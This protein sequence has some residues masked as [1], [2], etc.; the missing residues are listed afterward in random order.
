M[1]VLLIYLSDSND[2]REF[3]TTIAPI[4]LFSSAAFLE[5][6]GHEV[7]VANFSH[8]GYKKAVSVI[9]DL[10]PDSIG[11][12]LMTHNRIDALR[13]AREIRRI[14]PSATVFT[15]GPHASSLAE[16][17]AA[18]HPE[19]DYIIQGEAESVL[20][21]IL[22]KQNR[23]PKGIISAKA[24]E[25]ISA[26]PSPA[27]FSGTCRGI[28]VNE[29]FKFIHAGRGQEGE[30]FC[31]SAA[32]SPPRLRSA[33]AILRDIETA[34]RRF[35]IIFFSIRDELFL[36][37]RN[38]V[39]DVCRGIR[40]R[41]LFIMWSCQGTPREISFDLLVEMKRSGCERIFLT[42]ESGSPKILA[43][44]NGS[45]SLED[46]ERASGVIRKAGLY[47]AFFLTAGL[48]GERHADILKTIRLIRRALPGDGVVAPAVY[49][50]GSPA[51]CKAAADG[52]LS[53]A[54]F[55]NAKEKGIY[56]RS[57]SQIREWTSEIRNALSM[58][59]EK[60]WY[61]IKDFRAHR[62]AAGESWVGE[63]LEGDYYL[64]RDDF[65][66]AE[67]HY[68][69]V[70]SMSQN[71]PWGYLRMGKLRFR[72][73]DFASAEGYYAKVTGIV[74]AYYGGWLKLCESQVAQ[75]KRREARASLDTAWE[76][77]RW[78][79]RVANLKKVL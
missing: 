58:V 72:A 77:N 33:E 51:Y 3:S 43:R 65:R 63:I 18:R 20:P 69:N 19:I 28:N 68:S 11:I 70:I 47:L 66:H 55:F 36:S 27:S 13:L 25:D 21:S 41:G 10:A 62:S 52:I 73:G 24:V 32:S 14:L 59:R 64:D 57:D 34:F 6:Q 49:Y 61:S 67:G 44:H 31:R 38:L 45:L 23:P 26:L 29:Q 4:G 35:G 22:S 37:D 74:P 48:D 30:W 46:I 79:P 56:I 40:E 1:R 15:A 78:D 53:P 2:R 60:S 8:V 7:T 75:D 5:A 9:A 50:P 42:A 12:S 16:E 76:L 54:Q 39:L 17:I 71:N